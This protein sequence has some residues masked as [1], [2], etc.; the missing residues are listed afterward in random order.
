M[1]AMSIFV[2]FSSL[3]LPLLAIAAVIVVGYSDG[4]IAS[5]CD[6]ILPVVVRHISGF[7]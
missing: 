4:I 5:S 1:S 2:P 7:R 6:D 3:L